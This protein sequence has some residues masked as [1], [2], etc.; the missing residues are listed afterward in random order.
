MRVWYSH[1]LFISY[2][3]F[4]DIKCVF[5]AAAIIWKPYFFCGAVQECFGRKFSLS[6]FLNFMTNPMISRYDFSLYAIRSELSYYF[7][8]PI[9]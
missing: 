1:C 7:Y 9:Q 2:G 4:L 6:W 8:S 5:L 3:L